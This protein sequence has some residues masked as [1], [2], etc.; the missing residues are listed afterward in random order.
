MPKTIG[1]EC[2]GCGEFFNSDAAHRFH[3]V[4]GYG[5]AIFST[6]SKG[7][8]GDLLG[9][10]SHTRRC[11]S[12]EEMKAKGMVKNELGRWVMEAYDSTILYSEDQEQENDT[13]E[14]ESA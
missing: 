10:G 9:Y 4:G 14:E 12:I 13:E 2:T 1:Y 5:E 11:L 8:R 6:N 3:R 7:K